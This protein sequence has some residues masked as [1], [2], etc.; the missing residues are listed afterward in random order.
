M[1]HRRGRNP[2]RGRR[3]LGTPST[4]GRPVLREQTRPRKQTCSHPGGHGFLTVDT[5]FQ[6]TPSCQAG[7]APFPTLC[8]MTLGVTLA[9]RR[10][11]ATVLCSPPFGHREPEAQGQCHGTW[12]WAAG[13]VSVTS[14]NLQTPRSP[15]PTLAEPAGSRR[16][17]RPVGPVT[18]AGPDRHP[19]CSQLPPPVWFQHILQFTPNLV[20][21]RWGLGACHL[22]AGHPVSLPGSPGWL[23]V[24]SGRPSRPPTTGC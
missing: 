4:S 5:W 20:G 12:P 2:A 3:Q 18:A 22:A 15:C 16:A 24:G 8:T 19:G 23:Q 14:Q 9:V 1:G 21:G 11:A 6:G 13:R 10:E 7:P 17:A